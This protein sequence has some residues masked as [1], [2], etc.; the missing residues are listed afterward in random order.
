MGGLNANLL[1]ENKIKP[2]AIIGVLPLFPDKAA[3]VPMVKHAMNIGKSVTEFLNPCQTPVIGMDQPIYA[4]GK[5][6]QWKWNESLGEGKYVL[7]LGALHIEFVIEAMQGKLTDLSGFASVICE[8]GV[9][10]SGRAEAVS[11]PTADHHLK[12]TRYVH[13]VFLMAG[14]ILKKEA[15]DAYQLQE[16]PHDKDSWD[17]DMRDASQQFAYWSMVLDLEMLHCRFVRSLREGDFDLYV[18][19]IDELCGWMFVFDQ[20]NYSMWLPEHVKDMVELGRKHPGVLAVK[21]TATNR[22]PRPLRGHQ[23]WQIYLTVPTRWMSML[24]PCQISFKR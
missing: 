11:S 3:S 13:Q 18:Q 24:W 9:L 14:S 16:G 8:A 19:V 6:I 4:I 7:M 12:R 21:I 5:Q 2:K 20:T 10:T 17:V 1:N 22:R 15:Y 23:V